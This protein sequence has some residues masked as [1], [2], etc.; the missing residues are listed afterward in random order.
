MYLAD[1]RTMA[2]FVV[3]LALAPCRAGAGPRPAGLTAQ[4]EL[5][6]TTILLEPVV[7]GLASPLYVTS[8]RDGTNRLFIVEKGGRIKVLQPGSTT[9]TVFLDITSK[10]LSS[11]FEQGLLGL[12]FHPQYS[13]NRRFFVNYTRQTDGATVIAEYQTSIGDPNVAVPTE[14][15]ILTYAQP[16]ANHNGG[17]LAFGP[18][19][20]LYIASGD[21]GSG[22]DPGNRA[23]NVTTYLGKIL[24]IDVDTPNGATPYSSPPTNPFFG[25]TTGLD[26]IYAYGLR[27]PWRFSFDGNLLLVGDV[28]QG[29]WEEIDIVTLGGNYGWRIFEGN[30]CTNLDPCNTAG[31][32]FPI[33]E[34][35][36]SNGRCSIT[37]GYVYRGSRGSLPLGSYLYA[38]YCT[39][40][41]FIYDTT[42]PPPAVPNPPPALLLD[43]SL[44]IASFGQD[45]SGEIYVVA[46]GGSVLRVTASPSPPPCSFTVSPTV[47]SVPAGGG[48]ETAT[49]TTTSDCSWVAASDASWITVTSA[50]SGTG[51]AVLQYSVAANVG[52]SR[53]GVISV[54]GQQLV[55][56]Q[57]AAVSCSYSIAPTSQSFGPAGGAGSV[58]V[59]AP[60]GCAWT[61]ASNDAWI[62]VT[63]GASGT[64]NGSVG[65]SVDANASSTARTGTMTIADQ[66]FIVTQAG[67]NC[68]YSISPK[69]ANVGASGGTGSVRVTAGT[70]CA[71]TAASN[72][73]WIV[74][75]SGGSGSGNGTVQYSV[76]ANTT[77]S[78]RTGTM[79][80][81]GRTFTVK[82]AR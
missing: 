54:G 30:H 46:L 41:I 59:T 16:F 17:M 44:N 48:A 73:S 40:E 75:T 36:H 13:L 70:G 74:I 8:S 22:N 2:A 34:Y 45:E 57:D 58:A 5:A 39:G 10:I 14:T 25:P 37:A 64:G 60:G 63:S 42:Q 52:G 24:R 49:I 7:S 80:I 82:Q 31:L 38:D 35:A 23:Q 32:T 72:A 81:A 15:V 67:V 47:E 26:E 1:V 65:Y 71:W 20:Y 76:A 18:D 56:N 19:G 3:L 69:N 27:N 6:A 78:R 77:G 28:G 43:T 66:T 33:F 29:A 51:N 62:H 50:S 55:V 21:G 9:P 4:P 53:S 61:A 79:L 68:T 12:A 11:G